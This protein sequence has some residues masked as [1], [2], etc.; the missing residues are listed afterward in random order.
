MN[1]AD[2]F[3]AFLEGDVSARDAVA[4]LLQLGYEPKTAEEMLFIVAGGDDVIFKDADGVDRYLTSGK[5]VKEVEQLLR[6][7]APSSVSGSDATNRKPA[8]ELTQPTQLLF[9][10]TS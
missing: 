8:S 7:S 3:S 1:A 10:A 9:R 4:S 2:L 6:D 5:S